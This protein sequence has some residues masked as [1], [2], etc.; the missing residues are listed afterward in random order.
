MSRFQ[1]GHQL[2]KLFLIGLGLGK[3]KIGNRV[4]KRVGERVGKRIGKRI[5]KRLAF[6]ARN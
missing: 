2:V 1:C 6:R 4:G 3:I 5:G